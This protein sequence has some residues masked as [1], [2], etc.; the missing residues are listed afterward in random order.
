MRF[1]ARPYQEMI[2][3]HILKHERCMV[4]AG[5]GTG[6]TVSTLTAI[7]TLISLLGEGPALIIAPLRVAQSTWP[8]ECAKWAHLKNL[9]VSTI[10]GGLKKRREALNT[11]ADIYTINYEQ[12]PWLV[13]E[14]DGDWPFSIVVCDESTR[15]KGF[16]SRGGTQR[17]KA[18][19]SVAFAS[20]R[21]IELTGT[22]TANGL[23]D[24]WGQSWFI[25]SGLRLGRSM[26]AYEQAFFYPVRTGGEAYMVKWLPRAGSDALIKDKLFDVT[27][28]INA[29]DW[30]DIDKPIVTNVPV[31]LPIDARDAYRRMEREFLLTINE[32]QI[33]AVNALSKMNKCLQIASGSIYTS[34]GN[35]EEIHSAKLDALE[36]IVEEANGAPVLVAYQFVH[37]AERIL[38]RFPQA[39]LLDTN[40]KTIRD[41]NDGKIP[42]LVAHPASCGHGL[43]LQD[44]GN[45]L[46][47]FSLGYNYEQYAQMCE[48]IGPTRQAQAGHPRPVFIYQI[49]AEDTL[50]RRVIDAL[51]NKKDVLDFILG[52]TNK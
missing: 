19:A 6:K 51:D 15:L 32:E 43:N 20:T 21:F 8:D 11:H 10:T 2:I 7:E 4:W 22:P 27:I 39:R 13:A 34:A 29:E 50:D 3:S 40:P 17:A 28:T 35:F 48:R 45:I 49:I 44:G 14:C 47:F 12:I 52:R 42:I 30:F 26:A 38:K 9:K 24:L 16:R 33:E 25:D 37:E 46:V 31:R 1:K 41:W 18:L 5:M 36:S 23:I